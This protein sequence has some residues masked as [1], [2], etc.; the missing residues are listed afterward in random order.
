MPG[1]SIPPQT[2]YN[3]YTIGNGSSVIVDGAKRD[4][5]VFSADLFA[6]LPSAAVSTYDLITVKNS[7]SSLFSR[8]DPAT[9]RLPYVGV[10]YPWMF[11]ATYHLYT[12]IVLADYYLYSV[13][14][15]T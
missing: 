12:L 11:S 9:G 1:D 4:R 5:L 3:N 10:G 14:I 6:T 8:Q 7:L 13:G 2:W 15:K